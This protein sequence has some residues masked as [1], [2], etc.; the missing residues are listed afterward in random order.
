M[1]KNYRNRYA[2]ISCSPSVSVQCVCDV[3]TK[4]TVGSWGC[5]RDSDEQEQAAVGGGGFEAGSC[6]SICSVSIGN[7]CDMLVYEIRTLNIR[8]SLF[9]PDYCTVV[10]GRGVRYARSTGTKK[11][12]QNAAFRMRETGVDTTLFVMSRVGQADVQE[13]FP[14]RNILAI[15]PAL[16]I[17]FYRVSCLQRRETSAST[18]SSILSLFTPKCS[19]PIFYD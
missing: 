1:I 5:G 17:N 13:P 2:S 14:T 16:S 11:C 9:D 15:S 10:R 4:V 18:I 6:N 12:A 3:C 8:R 19:C 7:A